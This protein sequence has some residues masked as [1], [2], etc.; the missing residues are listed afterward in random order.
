MDINSVEKFTMVLMIGIEK[1]KRILYLHIII[2]YVLFVGCS[3]RENKVLSPKW[4]D[5]CHSENKLYVADET[6][7]RISIIDIGQQE[8]VGQIDLDAKPG[9]FVLSADEDKLYVSLAKAQGKLLEIDGITGNIIK[10]LEVGHTP[11]APTVSTDGKMLY[12]CDRFDN[13]VSSVN[14]KTFTI[15]N[16]AKVDREP[17][18]LAISQ[19][20][21]KLFVANHLPSG[22][23]TDDYHSAKISVL[24]ASNMQLIKE[25]SLP[26]GSNALN[27]ITISPDEKYAYV[28]HIL[29]R[30]NVPT[31]QVERGWINTNALSIIDVESNAHYCTV[32]LDDLDRGAA[33]PFDVKCTEDGNFLFVSHTGTNEISRI[34]RV[35]L[36]ERIEH[37]EKGTK[38]T[39][40]AKTLSE[41]QND[42]SFLQDI[43]SRITL[44]GQGVKGIAIDKNTVYTAMYFSGSIELVDAT[45]AKSRAIISL[46]EQAKSSMKRLG[47]MYFND[48]TLCKQQWQSC[49][50]CH[51]G[52]AR[53]DGLNWDNLNDGIG[54]P[55]NTKSML[56]AH[57]T[58]PSMITGIRANSRLAV[59]AGLE[60][61][62]FTVQS[63]EVAHAIDA[64]LSSLTP[65]PSPLL[66]NGKLGESALRGKFVFEKSACINCHSG[67]YHTDLNK[68]EVGTGVG[69]E[70]GRK[71]D[72]PT[73]VEIWRTAPYL[74]NGK[75]K[76]LREV[77]TSYNKEDKHGQTQHLKA[78]ELDDLIAYCLSL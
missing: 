58:P 62:L 14:L 59:R 4:M 23:A 74:Y 8:L 46:G 32:L 5:V 75:A 68:Y 66:E 37:V 20:G 69:L 54:N 42:L 3:S 73:L 51:P 16:K 40:Y 25:I 52:N 12:F 45:S 38:T 2:L 31:N 36:H 21:N 1:M 44:N 71:F 47:E 76:D 77:F 19:T 57:A 39:L 22:R 70:N 29:A 9:G 67:N 30:Y 63:E 35:A 26:N 64:Y 56:V 43:R 50:S 65:I 61:I 78:Q 49:V 18:A 53:V 34:N 15:S 27:K 24:D 72:T 10:E 11:M 48:A 28:T 41:I 33:N 13:T 6:A 17:V 60:H 7:N 55:K